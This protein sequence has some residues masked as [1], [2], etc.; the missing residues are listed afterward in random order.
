MGRRTNLALL[1]MLVAAWS[2][3]VLAFAIGTGWVYWVAVGHGIAG[4]SILFLARPKSR[5]IRRGLRRQRPGQGASISLGV[6][7]VLIVVTGLGHSTGVA[8]S[9]GVASAMQA[10]VASA[11]LMLPLLFWHLIVRPVVPRRTDISRRNA[12]RAGLVLGG[13]TLAYATLEGGATL[14][15]LPGARRRVSGSHESGSFDPDRMPVTQW[16]DDRVPAIDSAAFRLVVRAGPDS[17]EWTYEELSR[18]H[19]SLNATLD[20]TGG[21]YAHQAWEGVTVARLLPARSGRSLLVRSATGYARRVPLR[22]AGEPLLATRAE[23]RPLS[24]GHGYPLR[25]VAPARRGFWWVKWVTEIET[26]ARPWWL[27]FPFPLS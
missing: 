23:G 17:R 13:A 24:A 21:W 20:C 10:H 11:L 5:I 22:E 2:T 18:F 25:L 7:A 9:F 1:V 6:L 3:G 15:R 26:S 19:D 27:Q 14:A 12:L 4:F 16:F 8:R